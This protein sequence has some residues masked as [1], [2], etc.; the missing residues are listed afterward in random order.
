MGVGRCVYIQIQIFA[1]VAISV[2]VNA[3]QNHFMLFVFLLNKQKCKLKTIIVCVYVCF[4]FFSSLTNNL[5][6]FA[7]LRNLQLLWIMR[8]HWNYDVDSSPSLTHLYLHVL[9]QCVGS[10]TYLQIWLVYRNLELEVICKVLSYAFFPSQISHQ[11]V[12]LVP[13]SVWCQ[14]WDK[15]D[16]ERDTQIDRKNRQPESFL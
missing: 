2:I 14:T 15:K 12:Y 9:W 10:K 16:R 8:V 11:F 7:Y 3:L 1:C 4:F 6:F 13:H 5:T